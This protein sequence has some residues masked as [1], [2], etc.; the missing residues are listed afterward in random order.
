[1]H[2]AIALAKLKLLLLSPSQGASPFF[3]LIPFLVKLCAS[4]RLHLGHG[5]GDIV[6]ESAMFLLRLRMIM[7]GSGPAGSR[8]RRVARLFRQRIVSVQQ[9]SDGPEEES[10][11][12]V[13]MVAL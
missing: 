10:M 4:L 8:L 5:R 7:E 9:A 3:L 6:H 2:A 13:T 12:T 11:H 1:M